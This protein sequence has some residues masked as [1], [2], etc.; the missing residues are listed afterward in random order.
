MYEFSDE[1]LESNGYKPLKCRWGVTVSQMYDMALGHPKYGGKCGFIHI[2]R[3]NMSLFIS[4][5]HV[6]FGPEIV[7]ATQAASGCHTR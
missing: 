6:Q 2:F 3:L 7:R 4:L 5:S 1:I